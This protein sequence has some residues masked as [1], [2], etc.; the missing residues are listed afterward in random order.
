MNYQDTLDFLFTQIPVFQ[1]E[2]AT[3]YKPGLE[4]TMILAEAFGEPHVKFPSIHVGG[5]N[6]KGSTAHTLAAV[7]QS[8]GYKVGLY[9]SPHLVDFRERIRVNGK[10]IGEDAVID[11][12]ERFRAM[13]LPVEPSFF[14]LTMTMAFEH[15]AK[16]RVDIAVVEVGLGGR[17]DSTNILM[18]RLSV[19]TNISLD[20][21]ALLGD[22]PEAIAAEKAGIIKP[23]IPVVIGEAE[24][25]V[26]D[27]F[28]RK[29]DEVGAP[30]FF[31]QKSQ[32]IRDVEP[33]EGGGWLYT[34]T[35]YGDI[36]GTLAGDCQPL[37]AATV[38]TSLTLL[39]RQG[40]EITA[41]AVADGFANVETL[42]GLA[43]RWMKVSDNPT[44]ICDTGHNVG[45]WEYLSKKLATFA[46]RLK[47]VIGFVN[48]KDVSHILEMMPRDAGYYFTQA[49]VPRALAADDL[50]RQAQ[51]CG[52]VGES[53]E[54]VDEAY[55]AAR[56][57]SSPSDTIFVGGSTFVVA[58]FLKLIR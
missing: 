34:D 13:R 25:D 57:S 27:V 11:F 39:A 26:K 44:V 50:A 40:W 6:G 12:V 24:G 7:L 8:A 49:S 29:A 18:P 22:T 56:A 3:A 38:L 55:N 43:G 2:G 48:D 31:A 20:H 15:F 41:E 51:A 23:G 19:I 53:Y 36:R 17:L 52:L 47:M 4:R 32:L 30:I 16:E 45:G 1:R 21:M 37:N 14:E 46:P 5:T 28:L 33:I 9:T 10:M 54:S 42:T 58:D 35:P